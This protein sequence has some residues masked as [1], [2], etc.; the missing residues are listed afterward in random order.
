MRTV[1][2]G[3]TFVVLA[4]GFWTASLICYQPTS[5]DDINPLKPLSVTVALN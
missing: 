4:F 1:L 2:I 5:H 3:L